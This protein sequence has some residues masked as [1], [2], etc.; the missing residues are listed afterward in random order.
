MVVPSLVVMP[1]ETSQGLRR[2][3]NSRLLGAPCP[4]FDTL[5]EASRCCKPPTECDLVYVNETAWNT[6][7][8][9]E[10]Q[11]THLG[12]RGAR[13]VELAGPEVGERISVVIFIIDT[14]CHSF[15]HASAIIQ[16]RPYFY[17]LMYGYA[18]VI[19]YT[20]PGPLPITHPSGNPPVI[21]LNPSPSPD[22][23]RYGLVYR[24]INQF[25]I[26]ILR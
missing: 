8:R 2:Y 3:T 6:A 7:R 22:S 5:L 17:M 18:Q 15:T 13:R 4:A 23:P 9:C 20:S 14:T 1:G 19:V 11:L 16:F 21:A 26:N 12:Y 25:S 10:H 24:T